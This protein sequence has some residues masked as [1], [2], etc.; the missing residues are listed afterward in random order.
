MFIYAI[1]NRRN[2]KVYVG[3]TERTVAERWQEHCEAARYAHAPLYRAL[4]KYGIKMFVVLALATTASREELD[5]LERIWIWALRATDSEYGYNI[6]LGGTGGRLVGEGRTNYEAG[7]AKR[8][9]DPVWR[10]KLSEA[11]CRVPYRNTAHINTKEVNAKKG[12]KGRLF[13]VETLARMSEAAKK[14]VRRNPEALAAA[15]ATRQPEY[16]DV[17][18]GKYVSREK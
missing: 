16:R 5:K 9:S 14:R 4:R 15:R 7:I 6:T 12:R 10:E 1:R 17:K 2:G 8:S 3:K 18:T 13:S 11:A